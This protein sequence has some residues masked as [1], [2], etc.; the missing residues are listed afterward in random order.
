MGL[1]VDVDT[2]LITVS[3]VASRISRMTGHRER[4]ISKRRSLGVELRFNNGQ[5]APRTEGRVVLA[6]VLG[7]VYEDAILFGDLSA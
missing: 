3:V 6:R 7:T 4:I 2:A 1:R 5:E